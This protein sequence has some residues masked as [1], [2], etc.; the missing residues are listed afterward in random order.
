MPVSEG[1]LLKS[2][3]VLQH[4]QLEILLSPLAAYVAQLVMLVEKAH[5]RKKNKNELR[6]VFPDLSR[7][8]RLLVDAAERLA[9]EI[10]TFTLC[11]ERPDTTVP[12]EGC[13]LK[14]TVANGKEKLVKAANGIN[15]AIQNIKISE[16]LENHSDFY[17]NCEKL[18]DNSRNL[19]DGSISLLGALDSGERRRLIRAAYSSID[20]LGLVAGVRSMRGLLV[21][22]KGF[23]EAMVLLLELIEGRKQDTTDVTL[24][25][26]LSNSVD[27]LKQKIPPFSQAM[28]MYVRNPSQESAIQSRDYSVEQVKRCLE[29]LIEVIDPNAL[30][31]FED[32]S[33][34]ASDINYPF[35][36]LGKAPILM[37]SVET[38]KRN[39][40][41]VAASGGREGLDETQLNR[42]VESVA[43]DSTSVAMGVRDRRRDDI[44]LACDRLRAEQSVFSSALRNLK[45]NPNDDTLQHRMEGSAEMLCKYIDELDNTVR[46]VI[47]EE[48]VKTFTD[49][50]TSLSELI[51]ATNLDD[52][53]TLSERVG[54]FR[55]HTNKLTRVSNYAA[56]KSGEERGVARIRYL[57][58]E[59]DRLSPRVITAAETAFHTRDT[60]NKEH[61]SMLSREW[62]DRVKNLT[63]AVDDVVDMKEFI[64]ICEDNIYFYVTQCRDAFKQEE[65]GL[66]ST[67]VIAV[68]AHCLRVL[69]ICRAEQM[70][71]EDELFC[72]ALSNQAQRLERVLTRLDVSVAQA[73]ADMNNEYSQ[74]QVANSCREICQCIKEVRQ[75]VQGRGRQTMHREE[76]LEWTEA[77]WTSQSPSGGKKKN[78]MLATHPLSKSYSPPSQ[79]KGTE[80]P[81]MTSSPVHTQTEGDLLQTPPGL[82]ALSSRYS[83]DSSPG[84]KNK[85]RTVWNFTQEDNTTPFTRESPLYQQDT[86]LDV[87][88]RKSN[89][90]QDSTQVG[91]EI[92]YTRSPRKV[93]QCEN[94]S[95]TTPHIPEVIH[96]SHPYYLFALP[97]VG[98]VKH[99]VLSQPKQL[100]AECTSLTA[101]TLK[102]VSLCDETVESWKFMGLPE[103]RMLRQASQ[104]VTTLT[105]Q[106]IEEAQLLSGQS[107]SVLSQD[108]IQNLVGIAKEWVNKLGGMLEP[109]EKFLTP[110][111]HLGHSLLE[112]ILQGK[113]HSLERQLERL[114]SLS[115]LVVE[116]GDASL[117]SLF[118]MN[119]GGETKDAREIERAQTQQKIQ[120]L[121]EELKQIVSFILECARETPLLK[122]DVICQ[123]QVAVM[124]IEWSA[125]IN[126]LLSCSDQLSAGINQPAHFL[127]VSIEEGASRST[128][129]ASI[130]DLKHFTGELKE[131]GNLAISGCT[132]QNI[133]R[134]VRGA[135]R[136]ME[137]VMVKVTSMVEGIQID[138]SKLE[139]RENLEVQLRHWAIKAAI[140]T[141]LVDELSLQVSGPV[142]Q[143]GGIALAISLADTSSSREELK[144]QLENISANLSRKITQMYAL[145]QQVNEPVQLGA[146]SLIRPVKASLIALK[147]ATQKLVDSTI[148]LSEN[149]EQEN[150][151]IFQHRRRQWTSL[152]LKTIYAMDAVEDNKQISQLSS[153][154]QE[155]LLHGIPEELI[156][157]D[158][159][160]EIDTPP[161]PASSPIKSKTIE[162][163]AG[164]TAPYSSYKDPSSPFTMLSPDEISYSSHTDHPYKLRDTNPFLSDLTADEVS[165]PTD[166]T[167]SLSPNSSYGSGFTLGLSLASVARKLHRQTDM[168]VDV[169]N[170]LVEIAKE[171]TKQMLHMSELAK[172]RGNAE[173]KMEMINIAKKIAQ[174]T[175][176]VVDIAH[177]IADQSVDKR[178]RSN[179]KYYADMLPTFTNQL[180]ILADVKASMP[181]DRSAD[182]MLTKNAENLIKA[183]SKTIEAAEATCVKGLQPSNDPEIKRTIQMANKWKHK[184][185]ADRV[186][187]Q[188]YAKRGPLGLRVYSEKESTIQFDRKLPKSNPYESYA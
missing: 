26:K 162:T 38:V 107:Q 22:F 146:A 92:S 95:Q 156:P 2:L 165:Y 170:P 152:L 103:A 111:S 15:D 109:L 16:E 90:T 13:S 37:S 60:T 164:T 40:Q 121:S 150:V 33:V 139:V 176:Q 1:L 171:L 184:V 81:I 88:A 155:L 169:G 43:R 5:G 167:P 125:K 142:D 161:S 104:Q 50:D 54:S 114:N 65:A 106:V 57:S 42:E 102:L 75:L 151:N 11:S 130:A 23:T 128:I 160:I 44:L 178:M 175:Q 39:L 67:S 122:D 97:A 131:I 82:S 47:L 48:T 36:G 174:G 180:R 6:A 127:L 35:P 100:E 59:I 166:L 51:D 85:A 80:R 73:C 187:E 89:N 186:K 63:L 55:E 62:L 53:G 112:L 98:L 129:Q 19:L 49:T 34:I 79:S 134:Q 30:K 157:Q 69:D 12:D 144:E 18:I 108:D 135:S 119:R 168:Y 83:N 96:K 58:E 133:V 94:W 181:N 115:L 91:T 9:A 32:S 17:E 76:A 136:D 101:R 147:T 70:N 141:C 52:E 143:L 61:L 8:A 118:L 20:R 56:S 7:Q 140:I 149:S 77:S 4:K 86:P 177:A 113:R 28:Q 110:W 148:S 87:L 182:T 78:H 74:T 137:R 188:R 10:Q 132:D 123:E 84:S 25:E 27:E 46:R 116:L 41:E 117:E 72:R 64:V 45:A 159:V 124:C 154:V 183:V 173:S 153:L 105:P 120:N 71:R 172:A 158:E 14:E 93:E 163:Q 21:C 179:L 66:L 185:Y 99:I 31:S 68:K 145:A 138:K 3:S 126:G 24:K 29:N